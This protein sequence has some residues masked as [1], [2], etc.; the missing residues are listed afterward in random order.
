MRQ[1]V[2]AMELRGKAAPTEGKENTLGAKLAGKGAQGETVTFESQVMMNGETFSETGSID[3]SG[4]GKLKFV[5]VGVGYMAPSPVSGLQSGV[6]SWRITQGEGEFTG[7]TGYITS[8][9]TV[10]ADGKV[11]DNQYVRI[12]VV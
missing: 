10:A 11:V 4:R 3:Y 1:I 2:F 5:T 6:V 7:A 8:N 9:F 12:F